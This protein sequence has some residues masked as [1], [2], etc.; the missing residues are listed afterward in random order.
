MALFH[1]GNRKVLVQ[2]E[3]DDFNFYIIGE[4]PREKVRV[5]N[6]N[7]NQPAAIKVMDFADM[8]TIVR[9]V[10][11]Y[12]KLVV[13]P[14]DTMMPCFF[15]DGE[16]QLV[17]E[18]KKGSCSTYDIFHSGIRITEDFQLIGDS[19]IGLI[20]F[21]SDIG[22]TSIDIYKDR[23]KVLKLI[24]E[25]FPSK[26]DYYKDYKE[27]IMEINEEIVSLAFKFLDKTYLTGK[28]VSTDY[29]TN[30]EYLSILEIVFDDLEAALKR[31][32][33]KFKHNVITYEHLTNI[34]KAKR[35]SPKTIKY[36]R[37]HGDALIKSSKGQIKINNT[38]Y[39]TEKVIEER[40]VTTID[41][42][43]NRFVKYMVRQICRRLKSIERFLDPDDKRQGNT[44]K[45]IRQ[46]TK[47][48]ERYLNFYF[49]NISDLTGNKSM[50]LVFQMAPGY[51]EIYKK[52]NMLNKGLDLGDDL[53]RITPKKLYSL[54]EMWCYIKIHKILCDLG[55]EVEEYGIL[56]YRDS[57]M[58]ITLLQDSQAK[59]VYKSANN[60]LELWYNKSYSLP[61]TDQ[62][63]DT[64]LYIRNPFDSDNRIYIFD[65][66][67]RISVEN[68]K[69]GPM[70]EDI[71]VMHR[72][73]D[74]IVSKMS[75]SFKYKYDTFG[76]YILF[77]YNNEKDFFNH[78]FY[79]SIEEVNVGAFPMLPGSTN[80]VKDH[81]YKIV[82][83]TPLEAKS[84]RISIDEYDDY[85]RFKVENVMVVNVKD[86]IH[87]QA[88]KDNKFYHIPARRLSN[89]RPGV[90]YIAFYQSIKAFGDGGGVRYYAKINNI[91]K[92]KRGEC[93]ELPARP[94]TE[95]ELYLRFNLEDIQEVGPI[96]PIQAGTQ[97]VAYTTLYLLRNAENMHELKLK[98]NLEIQVYKKLKGIAK[99][100]NY[101]IRKEN[102]RYL[103]NGNSVE[104]LDGKA[105]KV[106]GQIFSYRDL[107]RLVD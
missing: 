103:I 95:D 93:K 4:D 51:K 76:A 35:I 78:R 61:T 48:L 20:G 73:R 100:K 25:V 81:L 18:S 24:I 42:F 43:E 10:T 49:Q 87:L 40:K 19:L 99:A 1:S 45:F 6:N 58:Y 15:E 91:V 41:I 37:T 46:K 21:S 77:P 55:Y 50:S 38:L 31:I 8:D 75:N 106:N 68:G 11:D 72:Y 56:Q 32:V 88:Y 80:L 101:K 29:Q 39:Y 59:M 98:S 90:E 14:G 71:N 102:D 22:Y 3:N 83:Q 97:I 17:L 36:F 65:A 62:R 96:Q 86:R 30:V 84:E 74:A 60:K 27:L 63:P 85:A 82:N 47:V 69:I 28:L 64:V 57:G 92:Y 34:H 13:N 26:L 7:L 33:N 104:I 79:K 5:L 53:F 9:T 67:Y 70:V 105:I 107:D 44:L 66:K 94:S 54:Y 23:V 2:L 16:Y 12:D 89:V 52:Y